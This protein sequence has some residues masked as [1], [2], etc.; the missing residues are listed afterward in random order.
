MASPHTTAKSSLRS[1]LSPQ[2]DIKYNERGAARF[3]CNAVAIRRP[4]LPGE[5]RQIALHTSVPPTAR[6]CDTCPG[7]CRTFLKEQV[8]R[9]IH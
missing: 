3:G 6:R 9:G 8:L 4:T 2:R 1:D 5:D 7:E